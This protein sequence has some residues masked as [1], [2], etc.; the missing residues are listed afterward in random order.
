MKNLIKFLSIIF[1]IATLLA[2]SHFLWDYRQHYGDWD[3][4]KDIS[5]ILAKYTFS[6]LENS[7]NLRGAPPVLPDLTSYTVQAIEAKMPKTK[8]GYLQVENLEKGYRKMRNLLAFFGEKQDRLDPLSIV[9][10]SGVYDLETVYQELEDE[11][12][13]QKR[14]DGVYI[15]YVPLSVRAEA[16]LIIKE[17]ETLLMSVNSGAVISSFG[18]IFI[19]KATVKGWDTELNKPAIYES[20]E[21][22]RPHITTWCGSNLHIAGSTLAHLG[23]QASKSYGISYTS[24]ADT[25]YRDDYGHL[26]GGTG[27]LIDNKFSDI[28][29]GFYSYE[30]NDVV[31]LGN[32]Y[33]DNIVYAIDPHD[34]SQNLIIAHNTTRRSMQKHGIIISREVSNS[35]VFKNIAEDNTGSGIMIDRNSHDNVVAYNISQKNKQDGLTF[36]ESPDNVS[37]KNILINNGGSG[38]RIRNSWGITSQE[39]VINYNGGSAIQLYSFY[40]TPVKGAK[41]RDLE[42]DPYV[43]RAEAVFIDT[44]MVGN[45]ISNIKLMDFDNVKILAPRLYRSPVNIFSGD[46]KGIDDY[47]KNNLFDRSLGLNISTRKKRDQNLIHNS[48]VPR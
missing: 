12:L 13:I 25:L 48:V 30:A 5:P 18:D 9:I 44:E 4:S 16:T 38:L 15:L 40:I 24:C 10:S 41:Y 37:Y 33:E 39:D 45:K 21:N 28:Y 29:F 7:E 8:S 2:S 26:P 36:Y 32:L 35:Y 31:I 46:L 17:N 34:R 6:S 1:L 19:V 43:Q 11:T 42:L 3:Q 14:K 47:A 23:Y 20:P 22:F 27:W